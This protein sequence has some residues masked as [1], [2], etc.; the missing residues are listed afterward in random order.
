MRMPTGYFKVIYR[1]AVGTEPEHVIGFL[2]PHSYENLNMLSDSYTNLTRQQAFWAFTSRIDVIERTSGVKFRGIPQSMKSTWGDDWFFDHDKSRSD[3]R[4]SSCGTGT[5][6]G[7][8]TN[9]ITQHR[10]N[11]CTD[12]LTPPAL[13]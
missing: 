10:L 1:P 4:S 3:L 12:Q 13:N 5:P 11:A 7:I 6:Q 9:S 2:L 8:L